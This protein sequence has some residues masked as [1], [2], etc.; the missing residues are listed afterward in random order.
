V[1]VIIA[2]VRFYSQDR[3]VITGLG[4]RF[5]HM[6]VDVDYRFHFFSEHYKFLAR[7]DGIEPSSPPL[8][9]GA[10]YQL[11]YRRIYHLF[12]GEYED[13]DIFVDRSGRPAWIRTRNP[14]S[15]SAVLYQLSYGPPEQRSKLNGKSSSRYSAMN[16]QVNIGS[17]QAPRKR[18]TVFMVEA[19]CLTP[20]EK[21]FPKKRLPT[22]PRN[23]RIFCHSF[24]NLDRFGSTIHAAG[25]SAAGASGAIVAATIGAAA[26]WITS[27]STG[28]AGSAASEAS[29][30][31]T[32]AGAAV[33][34]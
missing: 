24:P 17:P 19:H 3:I 30:L 9:G 16:Y 6:L 26:G 4:I 5:D 22:Y 12:T 29:A 10:W 23:L 1:C 20:S 33:A 21:T 14:R 15:Q 28:T 25:A 27:V 32:T 34:D 7:P 8:Q 18:A 11:S 13:G 2:L 31:V